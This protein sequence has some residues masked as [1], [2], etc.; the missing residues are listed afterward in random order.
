MIALTTPESVAT[1]REVDFTGFLARQAE[2]Y[3][4]ASHATREEV[5]RLKA[6]GTFAT[7]ETVT[8]E[9]AEQQG[10]AI[11]AWLKSKADEYA[12]AAR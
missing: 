12:E 3:T 1:D 10:L 8:P 11:A 6:A 7:S 4:R 9:I 5:A 2:A